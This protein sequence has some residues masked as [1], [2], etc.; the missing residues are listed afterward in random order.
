MVDM[1]PVQ[2]FDLLASEFLELPQR[3][4]A[5][6]LLSVFGDPERDRV[7]PK[8]VARKAPI[9][10]IPEPIIE[11]SF[12]DAFGDPMRF[13]VICDQVLFNRCYPNEPSRH[14]LIDQGGFAPPA[15]GIVM[16]NSTFFE[17]SASLFEISHNKLICLFD[18]LTFECWNFLCESTIVVN[19][20]WRV[21]RRNQLLLDADLVVVLAKAWGTV[22]DASA[23]RISHEGCCYYPEASLRSS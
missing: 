18:V 4:N 2:V 16:P 7:S 11:L 10:G 20:N 6:D 1:L 3:T 21:V 13:M 17:Q 15:E 5:N 22:Y 12:L 9:F 23:I 8:T 19:R 14:C